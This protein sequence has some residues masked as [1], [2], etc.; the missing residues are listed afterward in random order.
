MHTNSIWKRKIGVV[1]E[2]AY[3]P[4]WLIISESRVFCSCANPLGRIFEIAEILASYIQFLRNKKAQ[5]HFVAV[6]FL[7]CK[8]RTGRL[9]CIAKIGGVGKVPL[10][11]SKCMLVSAV[12]YMRLTPFMRISA[13]CRDLHASNPWGD[14]LWIAEVLIC[15]QPPCMLAFANYRDLYA[16]N[17]W[18][19]CL[20][21]AQGLSICAQPLLLGNYDFLA[22]H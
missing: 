22:Y 2:A 10:R 16:P 19:D 12:A 14:R 15:A 13:N 9:V 18:G 11:L 5:L 21:I 17:P 3:N 8:L 1:I 7:L 4:R 20:W 6:L